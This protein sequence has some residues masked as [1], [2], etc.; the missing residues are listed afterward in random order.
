MRGCGNG[1]AAASLRPQR[2]AQA[3]TAIVVQ[4]F[5]RARLAEHFDA[6]G[7]DPQ[8][9][10]DRRGEVDAR[11]EQVGAPDAGIDVGAERAARCVPALARQQGHLPS[12][13]VGVVAVEAH[14]G[15]RQRAL[16]APHR[17]PRAGPQED[18]FEPAAHRRLRARRAFFQHEVAW[19]STMPIACRYV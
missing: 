13:A 5:A 18:R 3:A 7:A 4:Q 15:G 11:D 2:R 1:D 12:A 8:F 10:A 6:H 9:A 14:A 19:L 16:D 17:Q